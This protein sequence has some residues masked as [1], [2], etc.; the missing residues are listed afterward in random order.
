MIQIC[1]ACYEIPDNDFECKNCKKREFI[2]AG[3]DCIKI[4]IDFVEMY[5]PW[6]RRKVRVVSHNFKGYDANF[7]IREL[8]KRGKKVEPIMCGMKILNIVYN[9]YINF[10]DSLNFL[11]MPLSKFTSAFGLDPN[12]CKGYSPYL[13][14]Q[15]K[16]WFYEGKVPAVSYFDLT[17]FSEKEKTSFLQWHTKLRNENYVYN[18]QNEL[19]KYCLQ[20]VRLLQIGCLR[21]MHDMLKLTEVNPLL[22]SFTLA[23]SV[24]LSFRK[25]FMPPNSLGICPKNNYQSNQNQSFIARK[26]LLWYKMTHK[27]DVIFE[28]RLQPHNIQVDGFCPREN[29]V[30]E[31]NGCYWHSHHCQKKLHSNSY[32]KQSSPFYQLLNERYETT[33]AKKA[34]LEAFGYE[35]VSQYECEFKE[36]LKEN[37]TVDAALEKLPELMHAPLNQRDAVYG[38][39]VEPFR[40]YFKSDPQRGIRIA[41]ADY[42]SLYPFVQLTQKGILGNPVKIYRG[43]DCPK[44]I[45]FMDGLFK[46][47]IIPPKNLL[48]PLLPLRLNNKLFFTLCAFCAERTC[49]HSDYD[50]SLFG[51]WCLNEVNAAVYEYGYKIMEAIEIWE[52]KSDQ[53]CPGKKSGGIFTN[54]QSTFSALKTMSSGYPKT[55][56]TDA[57]KSE[58]VRKYAADNNIILDPDKISDNPSYRLLSKLLCNSLW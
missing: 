34:R 45:Q 29:R 47:R 31:F 15:K 52:C 43:S 6:A 13:F 53:Y 9:E 3:D 4:F 40:L 14:N 19:I 44:D 7:V 24:L 28:H 41:A 17:R 20:D 11:P 2:F 30:L 36:F 10:I 26:W 23:Q 50:R 58:Y 46:G 56:C 57:E 49:E 51:T 5:R 32:G 16:N 1:H 42:C 48:I 39:R 27:I 12:F 55:V 25:K 8:L 22:Q 18:Q 35:L 33:K 21:F 54:F 38:G 37:P